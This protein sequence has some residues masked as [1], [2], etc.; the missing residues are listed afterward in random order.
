MNILGKSRF[1]FQRSI[2]IIGVFLFV[3]KLLAWYLTSSDAV[4]SDAMESIVNV[5][6][7]F[8]G[9]YSLY[10]AAKPRDED[11]PYGHGKIEFVTSGV[12]GVMIV[13]AGVMIVIEAINSLLNQNQL[14]DLDWGIAIVLVV[15]LVNYHIGY[16]SVKKGKRDI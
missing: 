1:A 16:L 3:G 9:L 10:L 11:H 6:S 7:A 15:G 4:Y 13:F 8:M 12:E 14:K 5:I 2:A